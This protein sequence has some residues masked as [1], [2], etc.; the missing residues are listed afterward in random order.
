MTKRI[1]KLILILSFAVFFVL[2]YF[3]II[4][5]Y[6]YKF[7]FAA[8]RWEKTGSILA[9]TNI[10]GVRVFIDSR[11]EGTTSLLSSTFVEK[12]LL[13]GQYDLRMEKENY[14]AVSK[15]V[16]ISS[17][18]VFQLV[19]FYLPK[20][21]EIENYIKNPSSK[22][23]DESADY[24][25]S[26]IDGLLYK[27]DDQ[28]KVEKLSSEPVYIK[29]F[30][31]RV[32]KNIFYLASSDAQALGVFS[33]NGSGKWNNIYDQTAVDVILSPDGKKL[34][35]IG[36]NQIN[37]LWL[38]DENEPPYFRKGHNELVLRIGQT[39]D[40]V[41]WFKTDWHLIYL[42]DSGET[43]FLEIDP[44]GGRNDLII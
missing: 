43:H 25:I 36:S 29:N 16:E 38:E 9:K 39:I 31:L 5:A 41:F 22:N 15:S 27:K 32:F 4:Y 18:Q 21:G 19:H 26:K 14:P 20:D 35:I 2:S 12:N 8:L 10:G 1:K 24:V 23:S 30:A 13:P 33:L 44:T 34:A 7:D 17:G 11:L 37:V 40:R 6:G 3:I 42:T 28:G